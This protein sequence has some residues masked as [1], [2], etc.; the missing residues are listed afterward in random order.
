M[1]N[2]NRDESFCRTPK[3]WRCVSSNYR[4]NCMEQRGFSHAIGAVAVTRNRFNFHPNRFANKTKL[5]HFSAVHPFYI[6]FLCSCVRY[7]NIIT[8]N[9]RTSLLLM[10]LLLPLQLSPSVRFGEGEN[11]CSVC[12]C[13]DGTVTKSNNKTSLQWMDGGGMQTKTN[14]KKKDR[15]AAAASAADFFSLR[16][17]VAS[18]PLA[19]TCLRA[20]RGPSAFLHA[21]GWRAFRTWIDEIRFRVRN[22]STH[23]LTA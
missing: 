22:S 4:I 19:D 18:R 17:R 11:V 21:F 8:D 3:H 23:R 10:L 9:T 20:I 15:R 1:N 2:E 14:W 16:C 6:A 7:I 12:V 13:A 5:K